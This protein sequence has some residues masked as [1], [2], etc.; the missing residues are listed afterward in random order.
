MHTDISHLNYLGAPD[1]LF[2]QDSEG[3]TRF[4]KYTVITFSG[5]MAMQRCAR[6][7]RE[8]TN[9][10]GSQ[11]LPP[12]HIGAT[13]P[14]I[15][16]GMVYIFYHDNAAVPFLLGQFEDEA[17]LDAAEVVRAAAIAANNTLISALLG[18]DTGWQS[19]SN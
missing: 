15:D 8:Y 2:P 18:A 12:S 16:S 14:Y 7:V 11:G 9:R 10:D 4:T 3:Q 13:S 5:V 6:F 19:G 17:G 1:L